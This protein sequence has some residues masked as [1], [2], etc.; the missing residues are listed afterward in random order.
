MKSD[1][2]L[3]ST[4]MPVY[5]GGPYIAEAVNSIQSQRHRPLE[6]IIIDDGST[7]TTADVVRGIASQDG[8]ELSYI[9]QP[10]QGPAAARNRGLRMAKGDYIA[11]LDADDL[12]TKGMLCGQLQRLISD[13][14]VQVMVGCTQRVRARQD[15]SQDSG[16]DSEARGP[17]EAFGPLWMAFSLGAGLFRRSV[18][19]AVGPL[20]ESMRYGEDVDWFFR[21]R[22]LGIEIGISSE[23]TQL[24]RIH[25]SNMTKDTRKSD[26]YFLSALK[27]SLDR[28]RDCGREVTDLAVVS[29]LENLE[30]EEYELKDRELK[31]GG[32]QTDRDLS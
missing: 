25:D 20:D 23:V 11:F 14:S 18:F 29:G 1:A 9:Y 3:V 28:R 2:P 8:Q 10:N 13:V 32:S 26:L 4:F 19:D 15:P 6:I 5:N 22:E 31:N 30:L 21:A 27:K 12:W 7:D 17:L 24:Y 16:Q